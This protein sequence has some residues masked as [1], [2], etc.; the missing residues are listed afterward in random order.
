MLDNADKLAFEADRAGQEAATS[1]RNFHYLEFPPEAMIARSAAVAAEG[2]AS[3][4]SDT[5]IKLR[6]ALAKWRAELDATAV[7]PPVA[8]TAA[9]E[10]ALA[11]AKAAAA[12]CR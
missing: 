10:V 9:L 1:A 6:T 11:K 8:A 7:T 3:R 2:A 4:A 5:A 12:A